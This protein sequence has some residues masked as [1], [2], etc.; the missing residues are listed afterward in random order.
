MNNFV[1][2]NLKNLLKTTITNT[3][4]KF[5]KYITYFNKNEIFKY[6]NI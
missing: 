2:N 5:R 6:L 3:I 1:I 4:N